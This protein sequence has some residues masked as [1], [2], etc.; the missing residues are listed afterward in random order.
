MRAAEAARWKEQL[1]KAHAEAEAARKRGAELG[2]PHKA[3]LE[4]NKQIS[5]EMRAL[6]H[7]RVQLVR[8][9]WMSILE[10]RERREFERAT[11]AAAALRRGCSSTRSGATSSYELLAYLLRS[12]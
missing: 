1:A 8:H 3:A 7:T 10:R 9:G 2:E 11:A 5:A 6:R 4:H 12:Q